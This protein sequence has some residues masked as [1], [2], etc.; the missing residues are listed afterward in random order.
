MS[1]LLSEMEKFSAAEEFFNFLGVDY[2]PQVVH[3]NRLH[4]LKR[5]QQYM[6]R[7]PVPAG[8]VEE[9]ERASYKKLLA[10]AYADF[11]KSN[12]STEKV[13][14]VFQDADGVQTVSVKK[15]KQTL[16]ERTV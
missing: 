1:N 7:D 14:K 16:A 11:V 6:D 13:F 10:M 9:D 15:L 2:D 8:L 4:I 3:V 5:F 12:A